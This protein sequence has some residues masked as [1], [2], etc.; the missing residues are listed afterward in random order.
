MAYVV[1]SIVSMLLG[2]ALIFKFIDRIKDNNWFFFVIIISIVLVTYGL[3]S[4]LPWL[5]H[6]ELE[7][8]MSK[9]EKANL[10]Y[11]ILQK[12][13]ELPI[14]VVL[15]YKND[16]EDMNE[17][18]DMS[19]KY[20]DNWYLESFYYKEVGELPKFPVENISVTTNIRNN[21]IKE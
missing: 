12:E 1:I 6:S 19:K 16:I 14:G 20:H 10:E 9:Y 21:N 18:I 7:D 11:Q 15:E 8:D 13:Y 3:S 17:L 5:K 4:L 2:F